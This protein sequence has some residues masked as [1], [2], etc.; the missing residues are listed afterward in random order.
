MSD[1]DQPF[2]LAEG[3]LIDRTRPLDFHFDG[4][5][6]RGYEGDTLA[7]ALLA[8]GVRLV[9]RSFKYHR[10]RGIFSAG[11]EEPNALVRLGRGAAA[12]PNLRAT[13]VPLA[14]G[15]DASAQNCWP[16]LG[17]DLG[18]AASWCSG[19]LP[20]GF[21]YKTLMA[22]AGLWPFYESLIRRAAG[23]GRAPEGRDPD[24]YDAC[25]AHC[26]LLVVGGG[27]AGLMAALA[28]AKC[29]ARVIL[30][31][32][33]TLLGGSLLW[34]GARLD[35]GPGLD[36]AAEAELALAEPP[37]VTLL[38]RACAFGVYD[39]NLVLIAEQCTAP[40]LGARQRLWK[41][42]AEK[43]LLA[44]GAVERP[45]VF[46]GNDTPGV[47]LASAVRTY[48]KRYAVL[49]G[50]RP[51]IFTNNESGYVTA[52]DLAEAGAEVIA[53]IDARPV[54]GPLAEALRERGVRV[55]NGHAVLRAGGG[56]ALAWID[57]A[58]LGADGKAGERGERIGCDLLCVSGGWSPAVHLYSQR[59]GSLRYDEER[60]AFL[61]D[62]EVPGLAVVGAA[63]GCLDLAACLAEGA[64]AGRAAA[65]ATGFK[66]RARP[67]LP[68]VES[69]EGGSHGLRPLWSVRGEGPQ[70]DKAFV[71]L[72]NDVTVS[73]L[74]LAVREGYRSVEHVKR[75]T[76][77]GMGTDQGKTGNVNAIGILSELTGA[78]M[79]EVGVTTFRP[80]YTPVTFG[81]LAGRRV[82]ERVEPTR[83]TPFH[84]C[85]EA[86][87]AVFLTSGAW[88]YPRYY[89]RAG[90]S[91]AEA[92]RREARNVR[93]NVGLVDMSTLGKF[94]LT[95][96]D[97]CRFLE[98]VYAN[99]M[100]SLPVGR[101]RYG[102]MLRED[103]LL[104][105]DGTVSRLGEERYLITATTANTARVALHLE[106]LLQVHWP[107]LDVDLVPVTEQWASLAVAGPRARDLLRA[108]EPDFAVDNEAFPFLGVREGTL[109]G[110]PVRVFRISYSGELGYEVNL[111]PS[112]APAL[113]N[114]VLRAGA[115][116]GI[117]PYGL[118]A[119]DVLRIE[120]GHLSIGTEIDGRTT[121]DDLGLGGLLG[122][123]KTF[124]GQALMSRPA[125][126]AAGRLQLVG[127]EAAD[128]RSPI[129]PG[130]QIAERPFAG[131]AMPSLGHVTSAV[132]SPNLGRPI[133]LALVRDGRARLG[134]VLLAV[135][136][137]TES[138]T[139]VRVTAPV[140]YDPEGARLRC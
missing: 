66:S 108:L 74:A 28:A 59:R 52:L 63:N 43:V 90:E 17:F 62:G 35:D 57:V 114:A 69:E 75:Y 31:E 140:F 9:G 106:K 53:V 118:E 68:S 127:L 133:A 113:W 86:A 2:R 61:A 47:M 101:A 64:E 116:L 136:P 105:D 29:G 139:A 39:G 45:L 13:Q 5:G 51:A 138:S 85:S 91:M 82:G 131:A 4:R 129:P 111:P 83:R 103:G 48:V 6:Y 27:P 87:G 50:R 88:L 20:A 112:L 100:A 65:R 96:P 15:L 80:P 56:R 38:K 107:D 123:K 24:S 79:S 76:T 110:L 34:N 124:L 135:S 73:D 33:D 10:P 25:H 71:D 21:Y 8:N 70:G 36:W 77:A 125:L 117:M 72:Q 95:G 26:D 42:R 132:D 78:T 94:E 37:N 128:G 92:I 1:R 130:T 102:L 67:A 122:R 46:A 93:R 84:A 97:A 119:L 120:K 19:L 23:L 11:A 30:A 121:A 18:R 104:L 16:M 98:R 7:S 60:A 44:S 40:S 55:L 99:P 14:D 109:A 81:A 58:S 134:E 115:P 54:P 89:P 126:A 32:Q 41:V 137:L 12:A 49:P 22:P 3:G